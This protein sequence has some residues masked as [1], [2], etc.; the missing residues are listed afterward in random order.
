MLIKI[1]GYIDAYFF[2]Y[3][4]NLYTS[5]E[6]GR[7]GHVFVKNTQVLMWHRCISENVSARNIRTSIEVKAMN[8]YRHPSQSSLSSCWSHSCLKS[9]E[10]QR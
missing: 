8:A 4:V 3:N 6:N 10:D 5:Q 9:S 7:V 2:D 1:D